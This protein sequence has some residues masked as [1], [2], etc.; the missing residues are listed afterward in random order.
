MQLE[1]AILPPL[2]YYEGKLPLES[3][4]LE[5]YSLRPL[6]GI[7]HSKYGYMSEQ[8]PTP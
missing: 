4:Y 2:D 8:A 6:G 3:N 5:G 7:S 1:T